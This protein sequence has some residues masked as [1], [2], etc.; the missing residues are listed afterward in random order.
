[1]AETVAQRPVRPISIV[2]RPI[3]SLLLPVPVVCFLGAVLTDLA[4][5]G[6]GGTLL[7][8]NMSS[9]LIA[10]GLLF[11]AIAG[12]VGLIDA[13]RDGSLW[14]PFG[15]LF[16]AWAVEFINSLVHARD[17]WTAVVPAGLILS[18]I[19]AFLILISGWLSQ[20]R[21]AVVGEVR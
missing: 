7:W 2:R 1:M 20:P 17:G 12:I 21:Y 13:I 16:A 10:A 4:Y 3:Y 19:G 14:I 18:I 11:G 9:W 5:Q 6:S 8:V 15:L